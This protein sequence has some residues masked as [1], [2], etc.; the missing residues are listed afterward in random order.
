MTQIG[1][2]SPLFR[3]PR[4]RRLVGS[5]GHGLGIGGIILL[6]AAVL[7]GLDPAHWQRLFPWDASG[8][9]RGATAVLGPCLV[10]LAQWLLNIAAAGPPRN[11]SAG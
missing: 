6:A 1:P 8:I 2:R 5:L 4:V 10:V 7:T 9:D 3:P 11:G